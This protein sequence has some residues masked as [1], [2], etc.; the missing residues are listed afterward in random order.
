M[1]NLQTVQTDTFTMD[2]CQFGHGAQTLVILPGLSLQKVLGTAEAIAQAYRLLTDECTIYVFERRN[3]LPAVYSVHEMAEDTARAIQALGIG[4]VS[5]FGASQGG[6][7]AMDIA[8]HHPALVSRLILGSTSARL[9]DAQCD[10]FESWRRL[11]RAGSTEAL[12]LAFGEAIYPAG[13]FARVKEPL[14][15]LARSVTEKD[16]QRFLILS[17]SLRGV[18]FLCDVNSIACPVLI[19]GSRDDR[20]LGVDASLEIAQALPEGAGCELYLYDGYGHAA[21]DLAP[22]YKARML[23]FLQTREPV[24][25]APRTGKHSP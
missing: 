21:Y 24:F 12:C 17:G 1:I 11:A 20:V 9:T 13:V 25:P 10:Q 16:L 3:E 14:R 8:I 15:A 23:R 4:P 6:M 2:Y 22:D 19:L 5:I 7:M 18:D